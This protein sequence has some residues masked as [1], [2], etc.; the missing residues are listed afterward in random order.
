PTG[1]PTTCCPANF[2][3]ESGVTVQDIFDFLGAFFAEE[4]SADF[5]G[6]GSVTVQDVFDCLTAYFSGC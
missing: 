5:N 6:S 1:N 2:N 4:A 3:G